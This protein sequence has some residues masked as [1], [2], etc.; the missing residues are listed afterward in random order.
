LDAL[1]RSVETFARHE[2]AVRINS[3]FPA[4]G[5][6]L[7]KMP[8]A[9]G[10]FEAAARLTSESGLDHHSL[11]DA[12]VKLR[13]WPDAVTHSAEAVGLQPD[14]VERS[15]SRHGWFLPAIRTGAIIAGNVRLS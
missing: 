9:K 11:S 5:S 4:G 12:L 13:R 10:D 2:E 15:Q 3:A 14:L 7:A 8:M 6:K 1:G